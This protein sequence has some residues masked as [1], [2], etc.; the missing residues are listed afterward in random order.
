MSRRWLRVVPAIFGVA[1]GS[2]VINAAFQRRALIVREVSSDAL[3]L[4]PGAIVDVGFSGL[5]DERH[6]ITLEPIQRSESHSGVLALKWEVTVSGEVVASGV[7]ESKGDRITLPMIAGGFDARRDVAY[8][9]RVQVVQAT[10][11]LAQVRAIAR[12]AVTPLAVMGQLETLML[13][14]LLG[15]GVVLVSVFLLVR[16]LR[17]CS[18]MTPTALVSSS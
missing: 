9:L 1:I 12:V 7:E 8:R 13:Q 3:E 6:L 4:Q 17:Q 11:E 10:P 2:F 15:A 5:W 14:Q 16:S 18:R